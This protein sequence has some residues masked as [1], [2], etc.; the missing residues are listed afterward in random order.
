MNK[1]IDARGWRAKFA[2]LG[3]STN[4]IVQP[5]MDDLRLPGVT[6]HY[7]RIR[8]SN[9][10]VTDEAAFRKLT[11]TIAAA[12]DDAVDSVLT[13]EPDYLVMGMSAVAFYG[14][15]EGAQA[16]R[17]RIAARASLGVS[18]GALATAEALNRFGAR[19]VAFLSPYFPSANAE[20]RRFFTENGFEVTADECLQCESPV[21]IAQVPEA[22]CREVLHRLNASNPDAIVQVGTNLSMQALAAAAEHILAK[23]V[24]AINAATWWHALRAMGIADQ[25]HGHGR[26]LEEF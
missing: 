7:S 16:F 10:A 13:C 14:G 4:T 11:D 26:L 1:P 8:V 6:A 2:V 5:D 18:T 17:A 15:I 19:R 12:V 9:M 21:A 23:P 22:R 3:P 24:I 20:V 25:I